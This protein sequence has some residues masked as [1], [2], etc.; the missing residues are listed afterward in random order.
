MI[1]DL[2]GH[3]LNFGTKGDPVSGPAL[4]AIRAFDEESVRVCHPL[5]E[6]AILS[7]VYFV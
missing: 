5:L 2:L 1:I 7:I 6:C 3:E 4:H